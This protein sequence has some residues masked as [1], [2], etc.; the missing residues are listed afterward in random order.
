M[1]LLLYEGDRRAQVSQKGGVTFQKICTHAWFI[2]QWCVGAQECFAVIEDMLQEIYGGSVY[3]GIQ[4]IIG[5]IDPV[6]SMEAV[7]TCTV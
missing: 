4:D 7:R 2:K 3:K 1:T 6:M 5:D